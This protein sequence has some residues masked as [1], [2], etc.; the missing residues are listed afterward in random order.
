MECLRFMDIKER[1]SSIETVI[2][3]T[4]DA[5]GA[6][7]ILDLMGACFP[8][9]ILDEIR[10]YSEYLPKAAELGFTAEQRYLH[11]L[12]DTLE[13]TPL[14]T[15]VNFAIPFR[16]LISRRLFKHCGKN[17]IAEENVR[18]NFGQNIQ[19]GDDVFFNRGVFLDSKGGITIGNRCALAEG[20]EIYTH[21]HSQSDH[22]KRSYAA[23]TIK[24]FACIYS[25]A[26]ILPGVTIGEQAIVA[27]K[28]LVTKDVPPNTM[29][30]GIPAKVVRERQTGGR[31]RSQLN[32]VWLHEG[33]FQDK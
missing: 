17:F 2:G 20:A 15:V 22:V 9:A 33:A 19:V 21:S 5:V 4:V 32:H 25:H 18:F 1:L 7:R 3:A 23:V 10:L 30:A 11:F 14:A 12:W 13:K 16:R 29:V 28:S 6:A 26:T 24:D 27:A 8:Q 31:I